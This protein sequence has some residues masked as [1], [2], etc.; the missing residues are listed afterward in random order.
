MAGGRG[1]PVVPLG[2][3]GINYLLRFTK[4]CDAK[5]TH[6]RTLPHSFRLPTS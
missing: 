5:G 1:Q 4:L 2:R 6:L 3:S